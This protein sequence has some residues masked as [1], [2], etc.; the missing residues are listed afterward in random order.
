MS[1]G[2]LFAFF[3]PLGVCGEQGGV[4]GAVGVVG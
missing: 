4:S 2:I 3:F 1:D